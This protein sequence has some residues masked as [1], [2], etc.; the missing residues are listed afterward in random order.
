MSQNFKIEKIPVSQR[1]SIRVDGSDL[2]G[3]G[4]SSSANDNGE[5]VR[6]WRSV[7]LSKLVSLTIVKYMQSL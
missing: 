7:C 3:K 6:N 1:I 2:E 4:R 5:N